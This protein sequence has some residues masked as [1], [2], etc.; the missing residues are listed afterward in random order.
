MISDRPTY[1][2]IGTSPVQLWGLDSNE[3]LHQLMRRAGLQAAAGAGQAS[4]LIRADHVYEEGVIRALVN[5]PGHLLVTETGKP[6]AAHL[7]SAG[8]ESSARRILASDQPPAVAD[9]PAGLTAIDVQYLIDHPHLSADAALDMAN[10]V[11]RR[12]PVF[13]TL[14]K[15]VAVHEDIVING[16]VISRRRW[17]PGRASAEVENA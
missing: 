14:R 4:L 1:S 9:L 2:I 6:V 16:A 7:L 17:V 13:A 11:A 8:D 12:C 15:A 10:T 3:R 5:H